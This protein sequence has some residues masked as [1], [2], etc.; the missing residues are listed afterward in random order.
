MLNK[1]FAILKLSFSTFLFLFFLIFFGL[2]SFELYL[3][4][5]ILVSESTDLSVDDKI[6]P[7]AITVC[8]QNKESDFGW[9]KNHLSSDMTPNFSFY[10]TFALN[11]LV[12][13]LLFLFYLV[14]SSKI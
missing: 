12:I 11:L 4:K 13:N 14:K 6:A 5:G 7:P 8:A 3:K 10:D 9:K 2:P 1:L